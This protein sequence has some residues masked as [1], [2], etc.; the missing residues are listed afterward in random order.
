[1]LIKDVVNNKLDCEFICPLYDDCSKIQWDSKSPPCCDYLDDNETD[2]DDIFDVFSSERIFI[3]NERILEEESLDLLIAE[4]LLKKEKKKQ[5][6]DFINKLC[7]KENIKIKE[8]LKVIKEIKS[9]IFHIDFWNIWTDDIISTKNNSI[10]LL[11]LNNKIGMINIEIVKLKAIKKDKIK[12]SSSET[13]KG[14]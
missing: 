5:R 7:L 1:M 12:N 10:N 3:N 6:K 2:I 8:L 11:K 14:E 4:E 9:L 13:S